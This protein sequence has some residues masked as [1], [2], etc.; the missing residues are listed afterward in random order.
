MTPKLFARAF[1]YKVPLRER[2]ISPTRNL[3]NNP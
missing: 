3:A 2:Y 1:L